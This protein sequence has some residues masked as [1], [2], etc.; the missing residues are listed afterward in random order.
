M[1]SNFFKNFKLIEGPFKHLI[2]SASSFFRK[3][4][5]RVSGNVI[6]ILMGGLRRGIKYKGPVKNLGWMFKPARSIIK[7]LG[8]QQTLTKILDR[9]SIFRYSAL[10]VRSL[11]N[12]IVSSGSDAGRFIGGKLFYMAIASKNLN[13]SY[14]LSL[15]NRNSEM[16]IKYIWKNSINHWR[17]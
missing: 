10:G 13:R 14:N 17:Y 2:F 6:D 3:S 7:N 1:S 8:E 5:G 9:K 15:I 11:R 12:R 16:M 4:R